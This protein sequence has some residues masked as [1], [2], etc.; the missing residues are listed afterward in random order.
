M[1]AAKR[2]ARP[3]AWTAALVLVAACGSAASDAAGGFESPPSSPGPGAAD[4][5]APA[6]DGGGPP[7]IKVEG[8]YQSPVAT[9]QYVWIANPTS[10]RVAYIRASTLDVKTVDAGNGPS[11]MA[12]VPDPTDDVALVINSL[13]HDATLLRASGGTLT[14]RMLPLAAD[15]NT[16]AVAKD[17]RWAIAWGDASKA[18]TAPDPT[19]GFQDVSVLDLTG[20]TPPTIVAVGYRPVSVAFAGDE[21]R[22]FAV[23]QDGISVVDL[24][25]AT[26][27]VTKNYAISTDPLD[28]PGTRDVSITPDGAWALV[29]RDGTS[30]MSR[31]GPRSRCA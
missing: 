27:L 23:T 22:A 21:T 2:A 1:D 9:G 10:G 6:I 15:A 20:S 8:D 19:A 7:E 16:W 17:G 14:T 28:D 24:A 30:R 12:A 5:S 3:V 4:G 13:P 29:R 25:G 18:A 26:P 31:R 11:T